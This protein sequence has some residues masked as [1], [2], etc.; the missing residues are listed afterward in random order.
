MG[1]ISIASD[2]SLSLRAQCEQAPYAP[3]AMFLSLNLHE[4][5]DMQSLVHVHVNRNFR[6]RF[7]SSE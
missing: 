4:H 7:C 1:R 3:P 2:A 6:Q 5:F